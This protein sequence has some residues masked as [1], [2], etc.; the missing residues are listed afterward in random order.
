MS[1][2]PLKSPLPVPNPVVLFDGECMFCDWVVR[3][4]LDHER[5]H[6]LLFAPLQSEVAAK[7]LAEIPADS[8][9]DSV[10][11]HDGAQ[12]YFKCDAALKVAPHLKAPW[13]WIRVVRILPGPLRD[14]IYGVIARSRYRIF[15]RK[16]V[17]TV[18]T[19]LERQRELTGLP[20]D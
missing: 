19:T 12:I 20:R 6:V 16:E 1:V 10:V 13:S 3:F 5:D 11:Y 4:I 9:P 15:G 18:P 2:V 14:A 8:I 17:C 7:L